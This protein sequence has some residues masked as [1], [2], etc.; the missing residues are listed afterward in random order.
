MDDGLL[1][2]SK[3]KNFAAKMVKRKVHLIELYVKD[4][5]HKGCYARNTQETFLTDDDAV[6]YALK[7]ALKHYGSDSDQSF[8]VFIKTPKWPEFI[9]LVYVGCDTK[10]AQP[11]NCEDVGT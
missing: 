8:S 3:M 1:S 5:D 2:I 4:F 10:G 7:E 9:H 11:E 6:A